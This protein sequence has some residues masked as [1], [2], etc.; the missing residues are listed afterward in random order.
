[1]L[2]QPASSSGSVWQAVISLE[3]KKISIFICLYYRKTKKDLKQPA[4][5]F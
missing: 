2:L 1:M 3:K 5:R 4:V